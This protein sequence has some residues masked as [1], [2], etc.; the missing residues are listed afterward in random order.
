MIT[1]LNHEDLL[2]VKNLKKVGKCKYMATGDDPYFE[3]K[4]LPK[5][6]IH[7]ISI[8]LKA[9]N[10]NMIEI[11][12]PTKTL[13]SGHYYSKPV[14]IHYN[15]VF[16]GQVYVG[17]HTAVFSGFTETIYAHWNH[18][19]VKHWYKSYGKYVLVR[20]SSDPSS[21]Y[22]NLWKPVEIAGGAFSIVCG[23][24]AIIG[25]GVAGVLQPETIPIDYWGVVGGLGE[26]GVGDAAIT[27]GIFYEPTYTSKSYTEQILSVL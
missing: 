8:V 25:S 26:I 2:I 7:D 9:E 15:G 20:E 17:P 5:G 22:Y 1:Y 14:T 11:Y 21:R 12:L 13:F 27:H 19:M 16:V 4:N 10:G 24:G 3:I 23:A 18:Q 6:L